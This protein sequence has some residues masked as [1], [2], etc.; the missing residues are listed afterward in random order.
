MCSSDLINLGMRRIGYA[1]RR[2]CGRPE[3]NCARASR[4]ADDAPRDGWGPNVKQATHACRH[5]NR[6]NSNRLT[7]IVPFRISNSRRY[8]S[9]L[10]AATCPTNLLDHRSPPLAHSPPPSPLPSIPFLYSILQSSSS[11]FPYYPF[12]LSNRLT[13]HPNPVLHFCLDR[14][15]CSSGRRPQLSRR[16]LPHLVAVHRHGRDR[17]TCA[18]HCLYGLRRGDTTALANASRDMCAGGSEKDRF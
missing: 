11:L 13:P 17:V 16:G 10:P 4:A 6:A 14:L 8:P 5:R 2:P 12:P 1:S 15:T 18:V 7:V 9:M 3:G